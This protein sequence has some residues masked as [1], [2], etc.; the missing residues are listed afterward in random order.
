MGMDAE[1]LAIGE[2]TPCVRD[3]LGYP[4]DFYDDTPV[5]ATVI[6]V[7]GICNTTDQ[8]NELAEALGVSSWQFQDHCG[9]S[10][11]NADLDLLEEA[12]ENGASSVV[13]FVRLRA[14]GFKFY[15]LPNG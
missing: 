9:L 10:G 6:T 8:S 14:Y 11:E 15:Y 13:D 7:V 4:P 12:F 2:Y 3:S 5:G 1:L